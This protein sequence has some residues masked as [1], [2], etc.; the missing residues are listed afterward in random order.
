MLMPAQ[1]AEHWLVTDLPAI[2]ALESDD[3]G[4]FS[5]YERGDHLRNGCVWREEFNHLFYQRFVYHPRLWQYPP[6]YLK[7][8]PARSPITTL[9][10]RL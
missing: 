4:L 2:C 8:A 1:A 5:F 7:L 3:K 6:Q 9:F 10:V